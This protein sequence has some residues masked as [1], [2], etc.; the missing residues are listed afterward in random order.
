MAAF[1]LLV[2]RSFHMKR[3]VTRDFSFNN[4]KIKLVIQFY[5]LTI[6]LHVSVAVVN[7]WERHGVN[8]LVRSK[9][10]LIAVI[11]MMQYL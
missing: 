4:F 7:L 2:F 11:F 5:F 8:S 1:I 9:M 10:M 3:R 6:F